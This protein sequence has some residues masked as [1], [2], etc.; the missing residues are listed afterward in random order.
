[1]CVCVCVC[2]VCLCVCVCVCGV[3][4]FIYVCVFLSV[5]VCVCVCVK[6]KLVRKVSRL[7]VYEDDI[8]LISITLT[9]TQQMLHFG[10]HNYESEKKGTNN[11][12]S[13]IEASLEFRHSFQIS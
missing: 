3:C 8:T 5:C 9:L 13:S 7:A 10:N 1:V 11:I 4:V 12:S 2:G 6:V